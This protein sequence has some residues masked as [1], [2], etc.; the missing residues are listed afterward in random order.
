VAT[1]SDRRGVAAVLLVTATLLRVCAALQMRR[2]EG[3]PWEYAES[4]CQQE[5]Q[6]TQ[7]NL[8]PE[9]MAEHMERPTILAYPGLTLPAVALAVASAIVGWCSFTQRW[10][11]FFAAIGLIASSVTVSMALTAMRELGA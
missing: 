10:R 1:L 5:A 9:C 8:D 11:R 7:A 2:F 3:D 4:R 6:P